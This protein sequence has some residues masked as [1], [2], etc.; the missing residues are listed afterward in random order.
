MN[1]KT[2]KTVLSG[3][4]PSGHLCIG[5]Y[6]GAIKN[7]VALQDSHN[8]IFLVVDLHA[9]TVKQVPSELRNRCLSFVAQYMACGIDPERSLIV[10]QSHVPQHAELNW[11]LNTLT[12]MGELSRM[13]Q[14]KDKAGKHENNINAGLFT[15]PVLM[16]A[17]ILIYQADLV[18][19]GHDQKQHLELARN[20]A[21]RF[22]TRYSETFVV[23]DGLIPKVGARV[24]SLQAPERKMSKSDENLNNLVALLDPPEV[25][26]RKIKRAVTDSGSEIRFDEERP[27]IYNL[28]NIYASISNLSSDEIEA[29][30][31][32]KLY[33]EFKAEL[34]DLLVEFLKPVQ[35]RYAELMQDK[36]HLQTLLKS[37]ADTARYL[38]QKTLTKVYRKV[39]FVPYPR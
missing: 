39:G 24:M 1:D 5:N 4:Q 27:G 20:V 28:L 18:P 3:I 11:I 9:L 12:Y 33:S 29:R 2:K 16:A 35:K 22:N 26:V 6:L 15:Y 34:S 31:A 8:C 17:D 7:W 38:A 13:T 23:P 19:V 14:F 25:I 10:I 32:G 37:G 30:F 36:S 21:Q